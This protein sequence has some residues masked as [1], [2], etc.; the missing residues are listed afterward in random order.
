MLPPCLL[1]LRSFDARTKGSPVAYGTNVKPARGIT[2]GATGDRPSLRHATR[3]PVAVATSGRRPTRTPSA[4]YFADESFRP[5]RPSY[6]ARRGAHP[7]GCGTLGVPDPGCVGPRPGA[8]GPH[9]NPG[10]WEVRL[11]LLATSAGPESKIRG[12]GPSPGEIPAEVQSR[13]GTARTGRGGGRAPCTPFSRMNASS[14]R[15]APSPCLGHPLH[16]RNI[17]IT[18]RTGCS[19]AQ[20]GWGNALRRFRA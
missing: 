5:H 7:S 4:L 6:R 9:S 12:T 15:I 17:A 1:L 20:S 16:Y 18:R 13:Q 2:K 19:P 3:K 10:I 8:R 11:A 14:T